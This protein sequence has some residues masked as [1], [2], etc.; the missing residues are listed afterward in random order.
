[1]VVEWDDN[2]S[3]ESRLTKGDST[4]A[5]ADD[6]TNSDVSTITRETRESKAKAY[7]AKVM[8]AVAAQYIGTIEELMT[9]QK[10]DDNKFTAIKKI[11][12]MQ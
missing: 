7:A 3:V 9:K 8:K 6:A 1:M 5:V 11:S 12:K 4:P 10:A 2:I